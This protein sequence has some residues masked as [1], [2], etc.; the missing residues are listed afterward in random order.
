[1]KRI[2]I[3]LAA[4][5]MIAATQMAQAQKVQR[6]TPKV[7][8]TRIVNAPADKVWQWI[9]RLDKLEEIIPQ[10]LSKSSLNDIPKIGVKRHCE[11]P[12]GSGYY[13]EQIVEYDEEAMYYCYVMTEGTIPAKNVN[14]TARVIPLGDQ[15]SMIIWTGYFEYIENPNMSKA[16][17][18]GFMNQA[19]VDVMEGYAKKVE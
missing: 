14:N 9:G 6:P 15:Q 13:K 11:T 17:F 1:M 5:I 12:D 19:F 7:V 10:Y 3:V 18:E 4:I 8:K 16:Q 2:S